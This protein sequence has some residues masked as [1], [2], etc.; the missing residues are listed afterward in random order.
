MFTDFLSKILLITDLR[1]TPLRPSCIVVIFFLKT[2]EK[3][4]FIGEVR[5]KLGPIFE[6]NT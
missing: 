6:E 4:D 2:V 5:L 3:F 1:G